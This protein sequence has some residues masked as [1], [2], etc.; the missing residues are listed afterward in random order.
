LPYY[1]DTL[2]TRSC[3]AV[4]QGAQRRVRYLIAPTYATPRHFFES[5]R[6]SLDYL[7]DEARHGYGARLM[8][9]GVHARWSGQ[10]GR[11]AAVRD[12]IEYALGQ[13]GVRFMSRI[14]VAQFWTKAFPPASGYR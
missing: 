1:T 8:T 7:L 4:Q 14:D 9:V 6:G 11:A 12:F 3:G 10:P 5:L 13:D 2:G